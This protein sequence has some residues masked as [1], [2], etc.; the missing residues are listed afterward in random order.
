MIEP[1]QL[2]QRQSLPLST[3]ILISEI[4]IREFYDYCNGNVYVAF[5]GGK[6]STVL[7]HL[8][9]NIYPEIPAVFA[10]TGLEY[11][12]IRE[13]VKTFENVEWV[14]PSMNFKEVLATYGYPVVSKKVSRFVNDIQNIKGNNDKTKTLRLTGFNSTGGYSPSMKLSKKWYK[15]IDAPFKVSPKCCDIMKKNP[16]KEYSKKTG[17]KG[18]IGTM[19]SDSLQRKKQ[20]LRNGCNTF[21][22]NALSHPIAFWTTKDIWDYIKLKNLP[23]SKIY[24]M[25]CHN[26]GC[27]FCMFGVHMEKEINRFQM[28]KKTHPKLYT[29]CMEQ[30]GIKKVLEYINV[31][32]E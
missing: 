17:R 9:R 7:L 19:A 13:F 22:T 18:I 28:M 4:R 24:D 20:Y 25:G 21:G 14:K 32:Y 16:I 11:P 8:V 31:P 27:M 12:E 10:D 23:Y 2:K 15:L 6:D 1:W 30:L 26:T 29:Y 5:S 3:K